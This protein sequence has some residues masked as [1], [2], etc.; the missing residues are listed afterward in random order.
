V[1]DDVVDFGDD[2]DPEIRQV[3]DEYFQAEPDGRTL[4]F[5]RPMKEKPHDNC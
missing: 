5:L 4:Q 3:L 2:S 1:F